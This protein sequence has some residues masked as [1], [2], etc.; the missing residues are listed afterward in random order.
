MLQRSIR[1][2]W[3]DEKS[4]ETIFGE[5][6]M[7]L[8]PTIKQLLAMEPE[9]Q[10]IVVRG[11]VRTKRETKQS[12]FVEI[13]DGSCFSNIQGVVDASLLAKDTVKDVLPRISTGASVEIRG[14]LISS[15]AKG[16]KAEVAV[17]DIELIGEAPADRYPFKKGPQLEFLREL[18]HLRVRTNTFGAVA[19]VRPWLRDSPSS[20]RTAASI[21]SIRPSSRERR[22]R[23]RRDVQVTTLDLEALAKSGKPVDYEKD[24][25]GKRAYL[26]VSGQLNVETYARPFRGCT[27]SGHVPR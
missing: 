21:T 18:A 19:R 2:L 26:T 5:I 15:P 23:R 25:F 12:V 8:L 17:Q 11:W 27:P 20:S 7:T 24:F 9:G 16:Q 1:I 6:L 13:N 14:A 10:K 22:R 3:H 4:Y